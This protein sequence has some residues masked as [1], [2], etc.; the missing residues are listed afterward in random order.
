MKQNLLVLL[1]G[2]GGYDRKKIPSYATFPQ[3]MHLH[4]PGFGAFHETV[5][6]G[7]EKYSAFYEGHF[8]RIIAAQ[9]ADA[10]RDMGVDVF[11]AHDPYDDTPLQERVDRV[12]QLD[13][14]YNVLLIEIHANSSPEHNARGIEVFTTRGVSQSDMAADIY[15]ENFKLMCK[16]VPVRSDY[17][18]GDIDKEANFFVIRKTTCP[19]ILIE[20]E[21]FD[22]PIGA[23]VLMNPD[24]Q[25]QAARAAAM[26]AKQ[27]FYINSYNT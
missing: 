10:A 14:F 3:K 4:H 16:Y 15:M 13:R 25:A 19:A 27:F 5:Y 26:T 7:D 1:A 6:R 23:N 21:F 11:M 8:N 18:D 9:I 20:H 22:H 12:N 2:H 17:S 24:F